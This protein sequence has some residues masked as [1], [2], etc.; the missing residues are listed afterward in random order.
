MN[1]RKLSL[2]TQN[3]IGRRVTEARLKMDMKQKD[4]LAQLQ[5]KGI[6]IS[7][8]ALSLLEGQKRPVSDFELNALSEILKVEVNWL[9]GK[10]K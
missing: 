8:P 4:L 10:L 6:D 5:V 3:M 1:K 2:G 7:I 9:L